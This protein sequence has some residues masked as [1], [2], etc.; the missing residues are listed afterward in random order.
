M[1]FS[2][3]VFSYLHRKKKKKKKTSTTRDSLVGNRTSTSLWPPPEYSPPTSDA[4]PRTSSSWNSSA[5]VCLNKEGEEEVTCIE[6]HE[7]R[8]FL[9]L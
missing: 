4:H 5:Q 2:S 3:P 8:V 6:S 9:G 1:F 7:R